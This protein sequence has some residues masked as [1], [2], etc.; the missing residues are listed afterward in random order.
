ML[1]KTG[2]PSVGEALRALLRAR[3]VQVPD[4]PQA[5]RERR[6]NQIRAV[7]CRLLFDYGY[8]GMTMRQ[9]ARRL[10]IKAASL[11]H[12]FPSKQ[13]ILFDLMQ[14]T[15]QEL[16]D[17]LRRIVESD[18]GPVEQLDAAV[19]WHVLFHT[20]KREEAFVS[21]SELRSLEPGFLEDILKLRHEYDRLFDSILQR[22]RQEGVFAI[23]DVSVTRNAILTM[24]TATA[25]WFSPGGRLTAEQ[26]ADQICRFVR[27]ALSN[28]ARRNGARRL[29]T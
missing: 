9:I 25:T 22:G 16:L 11:Y 29:M 13:I 14:T 12:H 4:P 17:G 27:A 20:Q 2:E 1:G 7:G 6:Y 21:H 26:V 18:D 19:R 15:V 10:G 3:G 5:P 8:A 23:E 28:K 24:C